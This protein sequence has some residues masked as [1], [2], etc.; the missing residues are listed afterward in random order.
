MVNDR[1]LLDI[2]DQVINLCQDSVRFSTDVCDREYFEGKIS[3]YR[4]CKRFIEEPEK[5]KI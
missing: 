2:L 4:D 5:Y 1:Q 3:A